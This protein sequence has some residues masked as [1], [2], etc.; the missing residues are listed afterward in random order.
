LEPM[1]HTL[2]EI[3]SEGGPEEDTLQLIA[4][5]VSGDVYGVDIMAVREIKA[6]SE[7]TPL[8]NTPSF[9]R[10]VINLRGVIIPIFDFRDRIGLGPTEDSPLHVVIILGIE[11]RLMGILVDAVSDILTVARNEIRSVPD[12][13]GQAKDSFV[14]GLVSV[15]DHMV[16]LIDQEKV[17]CR[18]AIN[19][20]G[21]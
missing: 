10:G 18:N 11:R 7:T 21:R 15:G 19:S 6:W 13:D 3:Q 16:G 2:D 5:T 14:T 12:T 9:V 8:P 1:E 17:C 4:F 20:A